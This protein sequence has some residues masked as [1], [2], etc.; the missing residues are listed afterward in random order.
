MLRE[1]VLKVWDAFS[2]RELLVKDM[3]NRSHV[4]RLQPGRQTFGCGRPDQRRANSGCRHRRTR[5]DLSGRRALS[6]QADIQ[7][8]WETTGGS[9]VRV[10]LELWDAETGQRVRTFKGHDG[11]VLDVAFSPDGTRMASAGTDGRVKVWDAISDRDVIPIPGS[12]NRSLI[13][14]FPPMDGSP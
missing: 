14:R 6:R 4:P 3:K 2:G 12:G 10:G 1:S 7:S 9:G 8:G 11:L 5:Q 13:S